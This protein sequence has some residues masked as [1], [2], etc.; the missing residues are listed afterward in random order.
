VADDANNEH[1][2]GGF[3]QR[4]RVWRP[5]LINISLV[6]ILFLVGIFMGFVF[7]TNQI[8]KEQQIIT[9]RAYFKN[10]VLTRRW[11]ANYGGV[12]IKKV[13]GVVS[14]PYLEN[15]DITTSDGQ[16]YTMKNPALMTREISSLAESAGDFQYHITSLRP[17][18]P[19]NKADAFEIK[20][21]KGFETGNK[22]VYTSVS[23]DGKSFFRYMAPL[24]VEEKCLVCHEK[25]GYKTG[26]VRGGISVS[27]DITKIKKDILRNKIVIFVVST[28]A[29]CMMLS[30]IFLMV[31]RLAR[32]L[33]VAYNTIEKMS[34]MDDL[35]QVFNRRYFFSRLNEEID[36]AK[37]YDLSLSLLF[38]DLDH[39]KQVND[40]HGHLVGDQ[41]LITV[42][43]IVKL[44]IRKIDLVARYGGEEIAVILPETDAEDALVVAEKIRKAIE[45]N[46]FEL[47]EGNSFNITSSFGVSSLDMVAQ[48]QQRNPEKII[49]LAD[50]AL[51]LAK[52][53]GRNQSVLSEPNL[54]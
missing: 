22:E 25:Q 17:L 16:V 13:E 47:E 34:I 50:D 27:F 23:R 14:N 6:I 37:R 51:Y 3:F 26:E 29:S 10:I 41:V 49:K 45:D 20:A 44:S 4:T 1:E 21:L 31:S 12:Y 2:K 24:Y 8:I 42:S 11:N 9:A 32:R 18:N 30:I 5:F 54:S 36:R 39:F 7:R 15:P 19:S 35:T 28:I 48:D 46:V 38:M 53:N 40:T 33:S 43:R 52:D